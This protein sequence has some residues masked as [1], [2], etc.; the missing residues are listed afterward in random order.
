MKL[1]H[2]LMVSIGGALLLAAAAGLFGIYE[3]DQAA[4]GYDDVV[5]H[6]LEK[7]RLVGEA[8]IAFKTQVQEWK[9]VLLRGKDDKQRERYWKAFQ[10]Q[11]AQVRAHITKAR[12]VA[13]SAEAD[14]LIDKF[15]KA[16]AD[17]AAGYRKGFEAFNAAGFDPSAGDKAVSGMDRAP[18]KLLD[19]ISAVISADAKAGIVAA[20]AARSRYIWISLV[21]LAV[22]FGLGLVGAALIARRVVLQIGGEPHVAGSIARRI[23][24]GDLSV[25][26]PALRADERSV[27]AAM[28]AMRDNLVSIVEQVRNGSV[29]VAEGSNVIADASNSLSQRVEEQAAT[30]QQAAASM[31][32][33][34]ATVRL[35]AENSQDA[36]RMSREAVG[37]TRKGGDV[38]ERVVETVKGINQS[39]KQIAD[40]IGVIDGI[41]FQTNILA[42]NAAVEAARAGEQG[43]GFAVVA[44][45]VRSLAQRSATAAK[46]IKALIDGSVQRVDLGAQLVDQAG[47]TMQDIV[48]SIERVTEIISAISHASSE[49]STGIQQINQ[50]VTQ[51]DQVTQQNAAYVSENATSAE[52]LNEQ[53]QTL[54][55]LVAKFILPGDRQGLAA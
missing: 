50:A 47:G 15:Q 24:A 53:A 14:V 21:A 51:M 20:R 45:E 9:N 6:E 48:R 12:A 3:I 22:V 33:L 52:R 23:A 29:S 54:V 18:A 34:S 40:I 28:K 37:I 43:R 10:D 42:L 46:E 41:A 49:Q 1:G 2:M 38:M 5:H 7:E 31:E 55:D 25:D 36:T 19:E 32:E 26:V 39:S 16:H 27:M 13:G 44:S 17:M 4:Q 30:L 35:N 11:E 8:L